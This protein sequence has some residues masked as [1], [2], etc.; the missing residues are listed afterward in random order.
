MTD[1]WTRRLELRLEMDARHAIVDR[2]IEL[3]KTDP[4]KAQEKFNEWETRCQPNTK[5][6]ETR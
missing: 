5:P 2:F 6:S 1:E 4:I 3:A